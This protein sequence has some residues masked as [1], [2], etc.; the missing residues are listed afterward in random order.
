MANY[1]EFANVHTMQYNCLLYF[2]VQGSG[3]S[4]S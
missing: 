1:Y 4:V 3:R 2:V